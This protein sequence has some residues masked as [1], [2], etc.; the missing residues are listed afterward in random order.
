MTTANALAAS[1]H[2]KAMP[3]ILAEDEQE[4]WSTGTIAE[5][6]ALSTLSPMPDAN[7]AVDSADGRNDK[8]GYRCGLA[9][10]PLGRRS[11]AW[12]P[13]SVVGNGR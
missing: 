7:S 13:Y 10:P 1:V 6:R 12:L 4:Q 2:C 3:M 11:A 9:A 5:V 8:G